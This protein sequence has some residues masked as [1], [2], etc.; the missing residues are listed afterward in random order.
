MGDGPPE[1]SRRR[2][3]PN[4][5]PKT[6][7]QKQPHTPQKPSTANRADVALCPWTKPSMA[8]VHCGDRG[9]RLGFPGSPSAASRGRALGLRCCQRPTMP[10][11][12]QTGLAVATADR[13][14]T[15]AFSA[16]VPGT[17][18]APPP[19]PSHRPVAT[20]C[21]SMRGQRREGRRPLQ[22]PSRGR[23]HW[24]RQRSVKNP[25]RAPRRHNPSHVARV[26]VAVTSPAARA[27]RRGRC[28][29]VQPAS[30]RCRGASGGPRASI[31]A[32]RMK[33][34]SDKPPM[35]CVW[36]SIHTCR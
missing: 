6:P 20:V 36:I 1:M 3:S 35:A 4:R 24:T 11:T 27:G 31:L 34:F 22:S 19:S 8:F 21:G 29:V 5:T 2:E 14:V 9:K 16:P 33:S 10:R 17:R 25:K 7:A 32:A 28:A 26:P 18:V 15:S 13:A 30:P 23:A 12:I